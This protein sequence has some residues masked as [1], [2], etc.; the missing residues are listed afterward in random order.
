MNLDDLGGKLFASTTETAAIFDET[1]PRT[2]RRA[3]ANGEIPSRR[4]GNKLLVPV[5]W[6]REQ[7]RGGASEPSA[8]AVDLDQLADQLADRVVAKILGAVAGLA[9][10]AAAA[11]PAPSGPAAIAIDSHLAKEARHGQGTRR[12]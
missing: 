5:A 12:D 11:G 3:I 1:D 10:K 2:I 8:P 6:L 7:V 4:V 9:L